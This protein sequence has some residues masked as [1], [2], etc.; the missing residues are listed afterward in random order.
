MIRGI[1]RTGLPVGHHFTL[2]PSCPIRKVLDHR[3]KVYEQLSKYLQLRNVI[4]R[5]Q[6]KMSR[7][8][9]FFCGQGRGM[10]GDNPDQNLSRGLKVD[11]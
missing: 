8:G 3:D 4:E 11:H 7:L 6:V 1:P 9:T 2:V 10:G 5:L